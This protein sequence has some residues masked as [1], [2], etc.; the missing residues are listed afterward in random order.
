MCCMATLLLACAPIAAEE[1]WLA[2]NTRVYGLIKGA[3]PQA[4]SVALYSGETKDIPLESVIAVRY[5][6]RSPLLVQAGMQEFRFSAGGNIRGQILGN[7][8]DNVQTLTALAGIVSLDIGHMKGLLALPLAGFVGRKVEETV[9]DESGKYGP[10]RDIFIDRL[11]DMH[12]CALSSFT[13]TAAVTDVD[14]SQSMVAWDIGR[15]KGLRLAN[16]ARV[17]PEA[18]KGDV[19]VR[20][21]ARDGS[22]IEGGLLKIYNGDWYVKPSWDA[23]AAVRLDVR[24]IGLVQVQGGNVQ[25]LSQLRPLS[26]SIKHSTILVPPQPF[27]MDRGCQGEDISICGKRYPW[28]IGVHADSEISFDLQGGF[29]QFICDAGIASR[30]N[31]RGSVVFSVL[32]DGA[33]KYASPLIRGSDKQPHAIT[34]DVTNITTLTLK[35]TNGDDLD[36]GDAANWGAAR[37]VR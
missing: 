33:V 27:K 6:G 22:V 1:I 37:V 20:V 3:S 35:V 9:E 8:G 31:G 23:N 5:L 29:K 34:V 10:M 32:G 16:G 30:M 2:D 25:Y 7:D 12:Q 11:G 14:D 4:L 15:M 24:E 36:L 13:R 28:G 26:G 18:W 17:E 19:R 21:S